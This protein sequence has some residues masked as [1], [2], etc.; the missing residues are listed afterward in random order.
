MGLAKYRVWITPLFKGVPGEDEYTIE[1]RSS[2]AEHEI[3]ELFQFGDV[4]VQGKMGEGRSATLKVRMAEPIVAS[5]VKFEFAVR[6]GF[7]RPTET[8]AEIIF[9]G[10]SNLKKRFGQAYVELEAHDPLA[11]KAKYHQVRRGDIALNVD[12]ERGRT[13]SDFYGMDT[14]LRAAHNTPEQQLRQ[15]PCFAFPTGEKGVWPMEDPP[16][17]GYERFTPVSSLLEQIIKSAFGPD[18]DARPEWN[19]PSNQYGWIDC[20]DQI[21]D[22]LTPDPDLNLGRY[23]VPVDPDDPGAGEVVYSYGYMPGTNLDNCEDVN[24]DPERPATH[25]H[26]YDSH[27]VYRETAA[28]ATSSEKVGAWVDAVDAGF[29]I[30]RLTGDTRPL[31]YLSESHVM[32]YG[33][34]PEHV[35][36]KLRPAD[37]QPFQVGHPKWTA[38]IV[39]ENEVVGGDVYFGD[40]VYVRARRDSVEFEG[41]YKILGIA[42]KQDGFNGLPYNV[43]ELVPAVGGI[44]VE[45]TDEPEEAPPESP[46][47]SVWLTD[48]FEGENVTPGDDVVIAAEVSGDVVGVQFYIDDVAFGS[49][50]IAA[51][52]T[53]TW[54]TDLMPEGNYRIGAVARDSSGNLIPGAEIT[55][56]IAA[57]PPPPPPPPEGNLL[58]VDGVHIRKV[59]DDSHVSMKILNV[60]TNG[61]SFSQSRFNQWAAA[62]IT[63]IRL[64]LIW[65]RYETS[66]GVFSEAEFAHVRT[67]VARAKAAGIRTMI[68]CAANAPKWEAR[69]LYIPW[70][71]YDANGPATI[72]PIGP[73]APFNTQSLWDCLVIHGEAWVKKCVTEFVDEEYVWGYQPGNEPDHY[74]AY[75]GVNAPGQVI[76]AGTQI[77]VDWMR[78]ADTGDSKIWPCM[79]TNYSSQDPTK[80]THNNWGLITDKSRM[81]F[82]AHCYA[83]P[84]SP[85]WVGYNP[86]HGVRSQEDGQFWNG[87]P[88]AQTYNT[89]NKQGIKNHLEKWRQIS[90]THDRPVI[91]D[92][93]GVPYNRAT[94]AARLANITDTRDAA[95]E[96]GFAGMG[97]WIGG[98]NTSG[99]EYVSNPTGGA[100]RPEYAVISGFVAT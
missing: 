72:G 38:G 26:Y 41:D 92:E 2:I 16:L 23:L 55:I 47:A 30:D 79:T 66:P 19:M 96:K 82:N 32:A 73:S 7:I 59:V 70:W 65:K 36:L 51:P 57:V 97:L 91:L 37:V 31:I 95:M 18:V 62:G 60:H 4:D 29:E 45:N 85:T 83:A 99:D 77:L 58:Y 76:Q 67:S 54:D 89:A 81:T 27:R 33:V 28:D 15:M 21:T 87:F 49:E 93:C 90:V 75:G 78:E 80:A 13:T 20:Y 52:Y 34:P 100:M 46:S 3:V 44:P 40:Y 69:A 53:T 17:I 8:E 61:F 56:T 64:L 98:E 68:C 86:S 50:D 94:A 1:G 5:L 42:W 39:T 25:A 12:P 9:W 71:S 84:A 22:H 88:A 10:Q 11:L 74:S 63:D 24:V 6:I 35:T 48:P 43:F 14:I